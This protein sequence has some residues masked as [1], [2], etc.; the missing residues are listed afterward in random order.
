MWDLKGVCRF[1]NI[2]YFHH[3]LLRY[4]Y[5][6]KILCNFILKLTFHLDTLKNLLNCCLNNERLQGSKLWNNKPPISIVTPNII[7]NLINQAHYFPGFTS[8]KS[9]IRLFLP[10]VVAASIL[11]FLKIASL[12]APSGANNVQHWSP[13]STNTTLLSANNQLSACR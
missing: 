1:F 11:N 3:L 4:C 7:P 9:H 13:N 2:H 5:V 10:A 8:N 6:C 12:N